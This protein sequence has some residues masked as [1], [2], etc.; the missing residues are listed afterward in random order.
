MSVIMPERF[1]V[2]CKALY[3]CS[4][5]PRQEKH[6]VADS[7]GAMVAIAPQDGWNILK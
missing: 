4:A 5:L 1:K 2:I 7:W 6:T 3:K